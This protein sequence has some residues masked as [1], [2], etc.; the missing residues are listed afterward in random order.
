MENETNGKR[1]VCLLKKENGNGKLLLF[2]ANRDGK[3]KIVFLGRQSINGKWCL[4]YQQTCPSMV[5]YDFALSYNV[6]TQWRN[7]IAFISIDGHVC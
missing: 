6:L 5:C 4:L 3:Q 1:H 2:S 7:I